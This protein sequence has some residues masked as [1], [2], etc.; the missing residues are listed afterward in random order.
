MISQFPFSFAMTALQSGVNP[1]TNWQN[2]QPGFPCK[3]TILVR[4]T[5]VNV[6]M[7][8][9]AGNALLTERTPVQTGGTAGQ[10]PAALT[11][12]PFEFDVGAG[13]KI[14]LSFDEV[15]STTPTVDG[16]IILEPY[17]A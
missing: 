8:A 12:T 16:L 6:R 15:A 7:T 4:A 3:M 17:Y 5:N 11:T 14:K 1:L 9:Y 10:T 13:E 2:D